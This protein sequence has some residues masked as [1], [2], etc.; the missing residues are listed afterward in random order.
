MRGE[1]V[2]HVGRERLVR[3]LGHEALLV[4]QG[5]DAGRLRFDE[6]DA[7]RDKMQQEK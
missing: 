7:V 2:V 3:S 6:G 4:E 1:A 5:Q